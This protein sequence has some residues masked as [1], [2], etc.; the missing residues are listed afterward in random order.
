MFLFILIIALLN[1]FF[2]AISRTQ[3]FYDGSYKSVT[4]SLVLLNA[5]SIV[6]F[7]LVYIFRGQTIFLV[8]LGLVFLTISFSYLGIL[9]LKNLPEWNPSVVHSFFISVISA[10]SGLTLKQ[11]VIILAIYFITLI[12]MNHFVFRFTH[13]YEKDEKIIELMD[14]FK[15]LNGLFF[16]V[17]GLV[18]ASDRIR[19]LKKIANWLF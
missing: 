19:F 5:S 15:V 18:I 3:N 7:A 17:L 6:L 1:A 16:F 13:S 10:I 11:A 12:L 14:L 2:A 9:N 4:K 8:L